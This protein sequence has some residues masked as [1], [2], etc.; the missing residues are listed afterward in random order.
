MHL[1][2]PWYLTLYQPRE[3][4]CGDPV[5][6]CTT[7]SLKVLWLF[8]CCY[9]LDTLRKWRILRSQ[10]NSH[11]TYNRLMLNRRP[12]DQQIGPTGVL[13]P[14]K[15]CMYCV[16]CLGS[17]SRTC[18]STGYY[19][20]TPTRVNKRLSHCFV[21]ECRVCNSGIIGHARPWAY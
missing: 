11:S 13:P 14:L 21:C 15:H 9:R 10:E 7:C 4:H 16:W 17:S 1:P 18:K 5:M 20:S 6:P 8:E 2:T 19:L 3:A 12:C